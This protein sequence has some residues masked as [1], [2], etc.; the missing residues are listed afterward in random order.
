MLPLVTSNEHDLRQALRLCF[1]TNLHS[2]VA[3]WQLPMKSRIR[4]QWL[5][6]KEI[7][8]FER[9]L[10]L[11][12]KGGNHCHI[13]VVPI[14]ASAAPKAQQVTATEFMSIFLS[15]ISILFS[16]DNSEQCCR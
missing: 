5:Q 15:C 13:N 4:L 10:S 12:K 3:A 16:G 1:M 6:G 2:K 8:A 14:Q 9:H 11:V 7:I